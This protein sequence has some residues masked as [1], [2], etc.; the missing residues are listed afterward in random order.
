M[1]AIPQTKDLHREALDR[2]DANIQ[3]DIDAGENFG[4][5]LLIARGGQIVHRRNFGTAAP[6]RDTADGD[7]YLLMSMSKAFTAA[8]V[9]QSIDRGR[10]GLD[11]RVADLVPG[12]GSGGKQRATVRQLLTHTAGLPFAMI[13]PPLGLDKVGDL[14]AKA[15]AICQLPA[16]YE[17]GT[18]CVYTSGIGYDLF[19]QILVN[20]DPQGRRFRDIARQ[21][22]FEPLGMTSSS[23]GLPVDDPARVPVSFTEKNTGPS[24]P[25]VL[26]MMNKFFDENAEL[27]SGNAYATIE[28]VFR[29]TEVFRN[30][31]TAFG[32]RLISPA[33]FDYARRDH[34]VGLNNEA[35]N[36][37]VLERVLPPLPARF[38][39][40]GGYVRGDG[41]ISNPAGHTASPTAL[42]ALGGASTGWMIDDE[43][44]LTVVFLSSGFREG[45]QHLER[46]LRINDLALAAVDF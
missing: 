42:T 14:A 20:T 9:L 11:T 45:L 28:D 10:F 23:F 3:A 40:L 34:T 12:F 19:G 39:L 2:L 44:D 5:S 26:A 33:L 43:R 31:G 38:N 29:F 17:P 7:R 46:F 27:P 30:R 4:A 1:N 25:G 37:E 16:S 15:A 21:E 41:H 24:S 22:L 36:F 13:P 8:L 18:R 32:Q 35:F 6:G